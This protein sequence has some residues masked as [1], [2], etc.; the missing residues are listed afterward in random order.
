MI[1]WWAYI[2]S[3]DKSIHLKRWFPVPHGVTDDLEYAKQEMLQ[4]N[5]FIEAIVPKPFGART[6]EDAIK[7]AEEI[8]KSMGC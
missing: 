4:G 1:M 6:H 7:K 8:F 2:H 3:H 5:D